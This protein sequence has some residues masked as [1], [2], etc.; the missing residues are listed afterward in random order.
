MSHRRASP[1][2]APGRPGIAPHINPTDPLLH[3]RMTEQLRLEAEALHNLRTTTRLTPTGPSHAPVPKGRPPSRSSLHRPPSV[4]PNDRRR[5]APT[6]QPK[7]VDHFTPWKT[8]T[9]RTPPNLPPKQPLS[10]TE[11]HHR[12]VIFHHNG[13][14]GHVTPSQTAAAHFPLD[15]KK[16]VKPP[17]QQPRAPKQTSLHHQQTH[18]Q[19]HQQPHQ[20]SLQQTKMKNESE[21]SVR[22]EPIRVVAPSVQ[23]ELDR[24]KLEKEKRAKLKQQRDEQRKKQQLLKQQHKQQQLAQAKENKLPPFN[25]NQ[26]RP[27]NVSNFILLFFFQKIFFF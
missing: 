27:R 6:P 9:N 22:H 20:Q 24:E 12:P 2:A 8:D 19:S 14:N 3:M 23:R 25:Q 13:S 18:H 1:V 15:L 26:I 21:P 17:P 11:P 16:P 7:P 5:S 10:R 4:A